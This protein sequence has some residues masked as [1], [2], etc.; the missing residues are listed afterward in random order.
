MMYKS[1]LL[2]LLLLIGACDATRSETDQTEVARFQLT[3]DGFATVEAAPPSPRVESADHPDLVAPVHQAARPADWTPRNRQDLTDLKDH[4]ADELFL[5][6]VIFWAYTDERQNVVQLKFGIYINEA[7]QIDVLKPLWADPSVRMTF[8]SPLY[9]AEAVSSEL[10]EAIQVFPRSSMRALGVTLMARRGKIVL[11]NGCFFMDD[12][13]V[14]FPEE[15][16]LALDDEGYI[17]VFNRAVSF[18]MR[19]RIGEDVSWAGSSVHNVDPSELQA[20]RAKCGDHPLKYVGNV[21]PD[22]D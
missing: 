21:S 18:S 14:I 7:L 15:A 19:G 5:S 9:P 4:L 11:K 3:S 6:K 8:N 16:G 20:L 2:S 13:L 1:T 12:H 17:V 10:T 22:R